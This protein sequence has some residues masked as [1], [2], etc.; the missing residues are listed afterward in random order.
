MGYNNLE[1]FI[2]IFKKYEGCTPT[3]FRDST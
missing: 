2:R 1:S 3:E